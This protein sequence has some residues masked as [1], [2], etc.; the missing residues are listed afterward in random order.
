MRP[1]AVTIGGRELSLRLTLGDL[2]EVA[3]AEPDFMRIAEGFTAGRVLW[4]VDRAILSCA[5]RAHQGA[6]AAFVA[7]RGVQEAHGLAGRLFMAA[8]APE[9]EEPAGNGDAGPEAAAGDSR[10]PATSGPAS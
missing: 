9:D 5:M 1:V 3:R 2:D 8:L 6:L 4:P 7:E 10:S